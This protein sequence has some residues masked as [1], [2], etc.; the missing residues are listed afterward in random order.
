MPY[1]E[2]VKW[3]KYFDRRPIGWR[4]DLRAFY[5]IQSFSGTKEKPHSIFPS[6]KPL[7]EES[8]QAKATRMAA[9]TLQGSF[10]F[11]K[12]IAAKGGDVLRVD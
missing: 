12:L 11:T 5:Q 10:L 4:E 1:E 8:E 2:Y 9:D 6:L 7:M 3:S